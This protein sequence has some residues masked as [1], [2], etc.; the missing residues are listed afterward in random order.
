MED[1]DYR[2]DVDHD[3]VEQQHHEQETQASRPSTMLAYSKTI[4]KEEKKANA[5]VNMEEKEVLIMN[6]LM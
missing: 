5:Q 2:A 1:V 6:I 4:C 3:E